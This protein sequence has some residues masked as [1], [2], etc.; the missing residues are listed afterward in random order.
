MKQLGLSDFA[1]SVGAAFSIGDGDDALELTL[2]RAEALPGCAPA[3]ETFRLEFRGPFAPILPQ[4]IYT[5]RPT[6][7]EARSF[8]IF[9]VP[10]GREEAGTL[11]EAIFTRV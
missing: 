7:R 1:D 5:F 8:D 10:V 4:A 3:T 9:I 11:Y 2:E 6:E